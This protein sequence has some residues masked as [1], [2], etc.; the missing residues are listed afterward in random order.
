MI[1]A[2]LAGWE[3]IVGIEFDTE[4]SYVDIAHKRME[5]WTNK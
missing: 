4:N 2:A 1:G 3:Q 5:Y